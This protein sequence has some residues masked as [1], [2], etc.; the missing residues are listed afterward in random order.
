MGSFSLWHWFVVGTFLLLI[1]LI[2]GLLKSNSSSSENEIADTWKFRTVIFVILAF[3][4]PF[5][6]ITLPLFLFLAYRSY[7]AGKPVGDISAAANPQHNLQHESAFAL[8]PPPA[9]PVSSPS[10][11]QEIA[12]L[13][14]LLE[15]GALTQEEFDQEKRKILGREV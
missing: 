9:I 3:V 11:A 8:D 5:W 2:K 4:I 15:Q 1:V 12:E 13:H 7:K 6:L 14:K 10:K